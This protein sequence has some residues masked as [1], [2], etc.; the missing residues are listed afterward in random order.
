MVYPKNVWRK[1]HLYNSLQWIRATVHT[2]QPQIPDSQPSPSHNERKRHLVITEQTTYSI[3]TVNCNLFDK[4]LLCFP[5]VLQEGV[6]KKKDEANSQLPLPKVSWWNKSVTILQGMWHVR[7]WK[8]KQQES[9]KQKDTHILRKWK[10]FNISSI[11]GAEGAPS[12][13]R[14]LGATQIFQLVS[15]DH[16]TSCHTLKF[17]RF[18][19]FPINH[20]PAL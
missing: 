20:P 2:G 19:L 10:W 6:R 5:Y 8:G 18:P 11:A 4:I 12:L 7:A 16:Y 14:D 1:L 3:N 17:F 9:L 15:V 13:G